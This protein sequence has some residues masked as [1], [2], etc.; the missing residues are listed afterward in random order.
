MIL[1]V[2]FDLGETPKYNTKPDLKDCEYVLGK[3]CESLIR[4]NNY[5]FTKENFISELTKFC[6]EKY[7]QLDVLIVFDILYLNNII[8]SDVTH[9]KFKSSF[10]ILFFGAKR[11]HSDESF[12]KYIFDSKK[13]SSFPEIIEF[14]T[15]ID[16][17]RDDALNILL[18]DISETKSIVEN[19]LGISGEINPLK[20]AKWQPS[21]DNLLKLQSEMGE[22]VLTSNLPNAVKDQYLD[23]S[24][25]Q[26]KPYNQS[27]KK[28]FEEYSLVKLMQQI[29]A[30]SVALRNSDYADPDIKKKILKEIYSSWNQLAKVL[31]ALSPIIASKGRADFEGAAFE[32]DG[33]FGE[34]FEERLSLILQVLPTNIVGYFKEELYSPKIGPL[35]FDSFKAET[36]DLIKHHQA[37]LIIFKRPD[38]WEKQI[39]EYIATLNKNS[40]YLY[41]TVNTLRARYRYD[42]IDSTELKNIKYLVKMGLAKHEF[43]DKKPGLHQIIKIS[44]AS[45]PKRENTDE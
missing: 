15:G 4:N 3:F 20:N 7:L 45:L 42:F 2:L 13:Y 9:Y 12:R 29:K 41:S 34:T 37:L 5:S 31:F 23:K 14:Y 1:F 19:K 17:N 40:F 27:I 8:V 43:G 36:N 21:E 22:N 39:E 24:Y 32:L 11:M 10:W 26:I 6:K 16:R 33:D 28:I 38:G 35:L 44:D 25:N 30:S 18:A